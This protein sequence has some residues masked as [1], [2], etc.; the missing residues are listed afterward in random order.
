MAGNLRWENFTNKTPQEREH[1]LQIEPEQRHSEGKRCQLETEAI[2]RP[3]ICK[4]AATKYYSYTAN[5]ADTDC[6]HFSKMRSIEFATKLKRGKFAVK[7]I[8]LDATIGSKNY[9]ISKIDI[10]A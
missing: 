3:R 10:L 9:T 4:E 7:I 6:Q 1:R 5:E 8:F 2:Q